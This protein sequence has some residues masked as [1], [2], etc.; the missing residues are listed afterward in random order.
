MVDPSGLDDG[1]LT[2]HESLIGLGTG[3]FGGQTHAFDCLSCWARLSMV[4]GV[5][6]GH[7]IGS[8][9]ILHESFLYTLPSGLKCPSMHT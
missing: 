5:E 6:G 8:D 2:P 9:A 3:D 1:S 7:I 4:V